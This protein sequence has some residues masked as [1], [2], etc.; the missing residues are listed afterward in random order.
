ME[1]ELLLVVVAIPFLATLIAG[2]YLYYRQHMQEKDI[3]RLRKITSSRYADSKV[4]MSDNRGLFRE[5][6]EVR[7]MSLD[8]RAKLDEH[9][10]SEGNSS[11]VVR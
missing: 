5:L 1:L 4:G 8:L 11:D 6:L 9:L 2:A 3:R 10:T 7:K